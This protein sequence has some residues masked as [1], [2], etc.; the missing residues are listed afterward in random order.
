MW[1]SACLPFSEGAGDVA[2]Q[3]AASS[4]RSSSAPMTVPVS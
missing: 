2:R 4:A 1:P 3:W